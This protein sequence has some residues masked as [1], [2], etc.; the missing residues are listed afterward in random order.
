MSDIDE[1]VGGGRAAVGGVAG[2]ARAA[3]GG[4]RAGGGGGHAAAAGGGGRAAGGGGAAAGGMNLRQYLVQTLEVPEAVADAFI[5]ESGMITRFTEFRA[6]QDDDIMDMIKNCRK[7]PVAAVVAAPDLGRG[8]HNRA[9]ARRNQQEEEAESEDEGGNGG[10][11]GKLHV[12]EKVA[13]RICQ[14]A[15]FCFHLDKIQQPLD[16]ILMTPAR[17]LH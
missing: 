14:L 5:E 17:L 12:S 16:P 11:G 13:I 9:R 6:F 8:A 3:G 15:Y 2:A 4:A 7:L 1:P 10:A